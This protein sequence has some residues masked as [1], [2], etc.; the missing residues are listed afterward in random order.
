[1]KPAAG[2]TGVMSTSPLVGLDRLP[3]LVEDRAAG[4]HRA[5]EMGAAVGDDREARDVVE[6]AVVADEGRAARDLALPGVAHEGRRRFHLF[7]SKS[8]SGPRSTLCAFC[9]T[10][11]G[12]SAK[13]RA[14]SVDDRADHRA[15]AERCAL[16]EL[17][18][19]EALGGL[20]L[21]RER[22]PWRPQPRRSAGPRAAAP[23]ATS[24]AQR[25][26]KT[27]ARPAPT[28]ATYQLTISPTS[29][30]TM[31][32][33]NPTG[34]RL[35]GGSCGRSSP[36]RSSKR[37]SLTSSAAGFNRCRSAASTT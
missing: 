5:T 7:S 35:G 18:S 13:P 12:T 37:V 30:Q 24:R 3:L 4:L 16:E 14:G 25:K 11:A 36:V 22:R 6:Q 34:H 27:S 26:P 29:R 21:R 31:P 2:R 23:V 8:S 28:A 19:R 20:G 32:T 10:N 15:E 9:L 33:A 1:M 17:V